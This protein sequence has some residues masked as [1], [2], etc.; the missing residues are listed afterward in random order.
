M[1]SLFNFKTIFLFFIVKFAFAQEKITD[2]LNPQETYPSRF[3]YKDIVNNKIIF[4]ATG[5]KLWTSDGTK[6]GTKLMNDLTVGGNS[7]FFNKFVR[8]QNWLYFDNGWKTDGKIIVKNDSLKDIIDVVNNRPLLKRK[9][10]TPFPSYPFTSY[11]SYKLL[12]IN[13]LNDSTSL[14]N[15]PI[16][17]HLKIDNSI[18]FNT[19]THNDSTWTF[20]RYRDGKV[21]QIHKEKVRQMPE[22]I[23]YY[24]YQGYLYFRISLRAI[25]YDSRSGNKNIQSIIRI[26]DDLSKG[27]QIKNFEGNLSFYRDEQEQKMYLF[28]LN[29]SLQLFELGNPATIKPKN[30]VK[31]E[32]IGYAGGYFSIIHNADKI[33]YIK[34]TGTHSE[35][36]YLY[37]F[38]HNL[39]D[40]TIRQSENLIKIFS[41]RLS[42]YQVRFLKENQYEI[43]SNSN[44]ERRGIYDLATNEWKELPI[45]IKADTVLLQNKRIVLS[46]TTVGVLNNSGIDELL[47]KNKHFLNHNSIQYFTKFTDKLLF[48]TK[49]LYK[50]YL[51]LWLSNG[52]KDGSKFLTTIKGE[53]FRET[54]EIN[55][56]LFIITYTGSYSNGTY[57][58]FKTNGTEEGTKLVFSTNENDGASLS[59]SYK[60]EKQ[61][62]YR[63]Q[64]SG[65][66]Y[67]LV[68][69]NENVKLIND[70]EIYNLTLYQTN[71]QTF[72][73]VRR[74]DENDLYLISDGTL[75]LVETAISEFV[76]YKNR[77]YFQKNFQS[78]YFEDN[79]I[80][81]V[82][83]ENIFCQQILGDKLIFYKKNDLSKTETT[84]TFIIND[85]TTNKEDIRF[86]QSFP[87]DLANFNALQIKNAIIISSVGKLIIVKGNQK[88]EVQLPSKQYGGIQAFANGFLIDSY[89]ILEYYD[90]DDNTLTVLS[91]IG[92]REIKFMGN[93]LLIIE[94]PNSNQ[95]QLQVFDTSTKKIYIQ[96]QNL[97]YFTSIGEKGIIDRFNRKSHYW[98]FEN[99]QFVE[100][101]QFDYPENSTLNLVSVDNHY[102]I[103]YY[104]EST[105]FELVE[106]GSDS[107]LHFPEIVKGSEGIT[108]NRVFHFN[109]QV[110]VIAFTNTYGVQVWKMEEIKAEQK[111]VLAEETK[112][113]TLVT[114]YPNPT[115]DLIN[116][117]S[118]Q[119]FQLSLINS[120]GAVIRRM[121][122]EDKQ[123]F[124]L[125]NL[126]TGLYLLRFENRKQVFSKKVVKF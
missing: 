84:Y 83:K 16:F 65:Q 51:E 31:I 102:Y 7:T 80:T 120:N 78:Y 107:L 22:G 59:Q 53:Y 64:Y 47:T 35:N 62:V 4:S 14:S 57:H 36:G 12:I 87:K 88:L 42:N 124:D 108:L 37:L 105:G 1:K 99:E 32:P 8:F 117:E 112:A 72:A 33:S 93:K 19:Y 58:F 73:V 98:V 11:N 40:N 92:F 25:D 119:P 90:L 74:G 2:F 56:Q 55:N 23:D 104:K 28:H 50:N 26:E 29:D 91:R 103:P 75:I 39:A 67:L 5:F 95:R 109:N 89:P 106:M 77:I 126:P 9:I 17:S 100:K 3:L 48:F 113:E 21:A 10:D 69:E 43:S 44:V 110:Y 61:V 97:L 38:E 18:Y 115:T 94:N 111:V 81:L 20:N 101:Y 122:L 71:T 49:P 30:Q 46:D 68:F 15:Q 54:F 70:L 86:E 34:A 123:T 45:T 63:I 125:K 6:E 76:S 121:Y 66:N 116:I 96:P 60:N 85:L 41:R 79:K 52:E 27:Y 118:S 82:S 24:F 114:V 13:N